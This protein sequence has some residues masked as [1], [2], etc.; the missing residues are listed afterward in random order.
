MQTKFSPIYD[1]DIPRAAAECGWLLGQVQARAEQVKRAVL[2]PSVT[3]TLRGEVRIRGLAAL[4]LLA[5]NTLGEDAIRQLFAGELQVPP[6]RAYLRQELC[7]LISAE[8]TLVA[9]SAPD[10][11]SL[12]LSALLALHARLFRDME[13]SIGSDTNPGTLRRA[14]DDAF[15]QP[16]LPAE[17]IARALER[18]AAWVKELRRPLTNQFGSGGDILHALIIHRY[19]TWIQ[20]FSVGNQRLA[21]LVEQGVLRQAGFPATIAWSLP[22]HYALTHTR[23]RTQLRRPPLRGGEVNIRDFLVYALQGFLD[24]L[25][26]LINRMDETQLAL[27]WDRHISDTL[28]ADD[29]KN[30]WRRTQLMRVISE[31]IGWN[32]RDD[33]LQLSPQ[34]S[35][36]YAT[37]SERTLR[38]DIRFLL[39][40]G[41]LAESRSGLRARKE[42][43]YAFLNDDV[44]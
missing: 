3:K 29:R 35:A 41:L 21:L 27:H 19:L 44:G 12:E 38:R 13:E 24:A 37:L 1:F 23:Y 9:P 25:D 39:Q 28:G 36:S 14:V 18:L 33:L 6:S 20:P 11:G 42:Q 40:A 16:T 15:P 2:P 17:E 5:G 7:N 30:N 26:E 34:L 32:D 10:W 22:R 8:E 43:L 4:A 31:Q